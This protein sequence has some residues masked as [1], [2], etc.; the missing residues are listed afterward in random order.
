[1]TALA[2]ATTVTTAMGLLT[3]RLGKR[4]ARERV[5]T[6]PELLCAALSLSL[7]SENGSTPDFLFTLKSGRITH[8]RLLQPGSGSRPQHEETECVLTLEQLARGATDCAAGPV[9]SLRNA[10]NGQQDVSNLELEWSDPGGIRHCW[11]V[12]ATTCR[13]GRQAPRIVGL[14]RDV[15]IARRYIDSI[16]NQPPLTPGIQL[17]SRLL[18]AS[19]AA[20]LRQQAHVI[21]SICDLL[22]DPAPPAGDD[23]MCRRAEFAGDVRSAVQELLAT[24]AIFRDFTEAEYGT[25]VLQP[26]RWSLAEILANAQPGIAQVLAQSGLAFDCAPAAAGSA[27]HADLTRLGRLLQATAA[28]LAPLARPVS[29]VI[30]QGAGM[31]DGSMAFRFTYDGI[32]PN[33]AWLHGGQP[34]TGQLPETARHHPLDPVVSAGFRKF[35]LDAHDGRMEPVAHPERGRQCLVLKLRDLR[36]GHAGVRS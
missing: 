12:S 30:L 19:V 25:L 11:L 8:L 32:A 1:M 33:E 9:A 16:A 5:L 10:L 17:R 15:S 18:G 27:L 35:M 28:L 29:A 24:A 31:A 2:L 22:S 14:V 26:N 7:E 23:G 21:S 3:D 6:E 34:C 4:L 36:S 20:S 13:S